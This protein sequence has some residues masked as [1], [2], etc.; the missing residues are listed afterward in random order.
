M[1]LYTSLTLIAFLPKDA[2]D[3]PTDDDDVS[4]SPDA[5]AQFEREQHL[6]ARLVHLMAHEDTDSLFGIYS[7]A[8]TQF[9]KGGMRRIRYTLVPLLFSYMRLAQRVKV[10]E[11]K[12]EEVEI[13]TRKVFQFIF[14]IITALAGVDAYQELS[15]RLFLQAARAADNCGLDAIGYEFMTRAF[16][17]YEDIANSELQLNVS[18]PSSSTDR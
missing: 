8:R 14:Q 1:L 4:A 10:R 7:S 12:G 15:L 17:L 18:R 9:G 11:G 13:N 16:A 2:D 3:T 5:A 6:V